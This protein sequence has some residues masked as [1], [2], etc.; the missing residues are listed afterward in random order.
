MAEP[1]SRYSMAYWLPA[2]ACSLHYQPVPGVSSLGFGPLFLRAGVAGFLCPGCTDLRL[3]AVWPK[4]G[5]FR[6]ISLH[7][8]PAVSEPWALGFRPLHDVA[9]H[10]HLPVVCGHAVRLLLPGASGGATH[11]R[12]RSPPTRTTCGALACSSPATL[13]A[14]S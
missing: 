7:Q 5:K 8:A 1:L 12:D 3:K 13:A 6:H 9:A 14:V 4:I 10:D 2:P 11:A